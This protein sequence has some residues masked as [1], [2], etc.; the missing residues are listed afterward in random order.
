VVAV[1]LGAAA[2]HV[3]SLF[4]TGQTL[5]RSDSRFY[6]YFTLRAL[7]EDPTGAE[8]QMRHLFDMLGFPTV[9]PLHQF[10][11]YGGFRGRPLYPLLST[12]FVALFGAPGLYVVPFAAY[13]AFA[14]TLHAALRR[15]AR[16]AAATLPVV[17]VLLT[18]SAVYLVVPLAESLAL[19]LLAGWLCTLPWQGATSRRTLLVAAALVGAAGLTRQVPFFV[20]MP[21]VA[22]AVRACWLPGPARRAWWQ[23]CGVAVA[24]SAVAAAVSQRMSGSDLRE[25]PG[26]ATRKSDFHEAL[27][28]YPAYAWGQLTQ[29]GHVLLRDVALMTLLGTALIGSVVLWRTV[30]PWLTAGALLGFLGTFALSPFATNL[31][32]AL[33][34]LPVLAVAAAVT[35]SRTGRPP[36]TIVPPRGVPNSE[37]LPA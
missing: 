4:A 19:A 30:V 27:A 32:L 15:V 21:A 17:L 13:L 14:L 34:A 12:P 29:E 28:A 33:P 26:I 23:A 6:L 18:G 10:P 22:L 11:N 24:A 20:V 9:V 5:W 8:T 37:E 7:G 35:L 1:A 36:E 25:L 31:R 3:H 16:P 2:L